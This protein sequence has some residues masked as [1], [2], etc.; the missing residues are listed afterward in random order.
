MVSLLGL[1]AV[2]WGLVLLP[3]HTQILNFILLALLAAA[4]QFATTSVPISKKAGIT[5]EVGTAVAMAA[6]PFYG[7]AAAAV[8]VAF[9][10]L[11]IWLAK[12]HNEVTWKKSWRQLSFNTG[13]WSIAIFVAGEIFIYLEG[14]FGDYLFLSQAILWII[15]A[16]INT[17]VNFWLL[18]IMIRLQHGSQVKPLELWKENSWAATI[19][20]LVKGGGGAFL[21]FAIGS[22]NSTGIV[23]FFLP[24]LLSAYA[25]RLYVR[26]M[27]G[28]MDNL[29]E[30]IAER[31]K[32]L[33]ELMREKDAYLAVLSHDMK[34]PL[35]TIGMYSEMLVQFPDLI[36]KKPEVAKIM[37]TNQQALT[38]MVHNILDL[39]KLQV[40]GSFKLDIET[41][42]LIPALETVIDLVSIQA[43]RKSIV[44]NQNYSTPSL[45]IT[46]DKQQVKRVFQNLLSN[47]IKYSAK[48]SEVAL[49]MQLNGKSVSLSVIDT[50]YGI[51]DDEL[52]YIFDH[53]RRVEKY[54]RI[55]AGTGIGL[56][57][58]KA[59][60]ETHG[61]EIS[62]RSVE[63]EGSEFSV[64]LPL[65]AKY[66][67]K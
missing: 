38:E 45:P 3:T 44:I 20:I 43:D 29:E 51:P 23:V 54:A 18:V 16:V 31:T 60:V 25:F 56:A 52:P 37:R 24:I 63:G 2:F 67:V 26:Q 27:Q 15:A 4:S 57:I 19:D 17:L 32:E 28:H 41:F 9:S 50:G 13:M 61:G 5:F 21:A 12:S 34:T 46:A 35:T 42:D 36:Q 48:E 65:E 66:T 8:I 30:M 14:F 22:Y 33:S 47:A 11:S 55:A 64:T 53:Y 62:V 58:V 10:S 59:I 40:G 49:D 39:E 6:I 7:S 1:A